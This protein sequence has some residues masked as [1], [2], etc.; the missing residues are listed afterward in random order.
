[1]INIV[2]RYQEWTRSV[3]GRKLLGVN[4]VIYSLETHDFNHP[5]QLQLV[6][7][8]VEEMKSFKCGR[9]GSTLELTDLP[10]QGND[11]GEYGREM[12]IDISHIY[13]FVNYIGK[14]VLKAFLIFSSLE[15]AFIGVKLVFEVELTFF[16]MNIGDE[17]SI[18][19][20]L[21]SS[22]EQDEGVKYQQL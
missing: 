9:D 7:S 21:S 14:K 3:V 13:P 2:G 1:M 22:Y 8:E 17:I 20:S 4:G 18:F 16:I 10:L 12:V 15:E 6:F 11:L 5:Q 19:E